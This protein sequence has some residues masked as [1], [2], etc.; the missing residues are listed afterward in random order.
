[1]QSLK[2][3]S[4]YNSYYSDFKIATKIVNNFESSWFL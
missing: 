2:S 4:S 3:L 1:M